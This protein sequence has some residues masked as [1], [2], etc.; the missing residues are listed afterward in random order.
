M[1][2]AAVMRALGWTWKSR[3]SGLMCR[4]R[5]RMWSLWFVLTE[6]PEGNVAFVATLMQL[7]LHLTSGMLHSFNSVLHVCAVS[8]WLVN[9]V[10]DALSCSPTLGS[11]CVSKLEWVMNFYFPK[12]L[13]LRARK[14]GPESLNSVDS[15]SSQTEGDFESRL[16]LI[17][18]PYW[19]NKVHLWLLLSY[20]LV[21]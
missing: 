1:W 19:V 20:S 2:V 17:S 21:P 15:I 6:Q 4:R 18:F 16:H 7:T 9:I 3:A 14:C 12:Q 11:V 10:P 8:L 5:R 13:G